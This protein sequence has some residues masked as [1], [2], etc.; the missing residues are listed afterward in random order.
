M[1]YQLPEIGDHK[2]IEIRDREAQSPTPE[3][4]V[5]P[6]IANDPKR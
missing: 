3:A 2:H 6:E 4:S 5:S 1:S